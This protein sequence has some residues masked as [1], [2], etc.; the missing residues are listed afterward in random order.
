VVELARLYAEQALPLHKM[1]AE[2]TSTT[3]KVVVYHCFVQNETGHWVGFLRRLGIRN[4]ACDLESHVRGKLARYTFI[5]YY[6]EL[7]KMNIGEKINHWMTENYK[8]SQAVFFN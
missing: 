3:I 7:L 2:K 8:T 4:V 6:K 5:F 1:K